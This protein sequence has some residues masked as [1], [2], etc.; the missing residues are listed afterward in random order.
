[1]NSLISC[2]M[3]FL[4][5]VADEEWD[6]FCSA[7]K[8]ASKPISIRKQAKKCFVDNPTVC[9]GLG[10]VPRGLEAALVLPKMGFGLV[11]CD[12]GMLV[13]YNRKFNPNKLK[14]RHPLQQLTSTSRKPCVCGRN[15]RM[16][17]R[18]KSQSGKVCRGSTV[19]MNSW[20]HMN[21]DVAPKIWPGLYV[22]HNPDKLGQMVLLP[23]DIQSRSSN[24]Y[25]YM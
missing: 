5:S 6:E 4:L 3:D 16:T 17:A 7:S 20:T 15:K 18:V 22:P 8:T 10:L 25:W 9:R 11:F 24:E 14:K 21:D 19:I 1:M 2:V 12:L 13:S 23:V